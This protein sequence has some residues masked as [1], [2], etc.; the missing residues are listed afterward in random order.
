MLFNL[1]TNNTIVC[2]EKK[3]LAKAI[4]PLFIL[5]YGPGRAHNSL[6]LLADNLHVNKTRTQVKGKN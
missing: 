1:V 3:L 4:F 2:F 5:V 6:V